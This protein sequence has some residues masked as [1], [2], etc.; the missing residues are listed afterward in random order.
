MAHVEIE[1]GFD[2]AIKASDFAKNG[3]DRLYAGDDQN[4]REG[5]H[6]AISRSH[7][8][9]P[10]TDPYTNLC[11]RNVGTATLSCG[12]FLGTAR[13]PAHRHSGQRRPG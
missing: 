10:Q 7:L 13:L 2:P 3:V 8:T 12:R 6:W 9:L 11:P 5:N 1:S 4:G